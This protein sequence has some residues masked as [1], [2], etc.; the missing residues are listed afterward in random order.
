MGY[1][2]DFVNAVRRSFIPQIHYLLQGSFDGYAI[3]HTSADEYALTA[4]C[5]EET[6]EEIL[7]SLGFSRNPIAALKVRTD[8]NTS[9]GSWVWRP[10]PLSSYQVHIVLHELENEAGVDVYAHWECSWIRHP[11]KHY[12]THGYDAEKGVTLAR[13]WLTNYAGEEL[14]GR[15]IEFEIDDSPARQASEYF[16]LS[17]YQIEE[18]LAAIRS[19]L[20]FMDGDGSLTIDRDDER[21]GVSPRIVDQ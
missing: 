4:H 15:G 3:S 1:T 6:L 17:Y 8:G 14:E 9:E 16:S 18:H 21:D 2:E 5:S 10:S 20:P 13:R 19:T 7:S 12:A 11:Y